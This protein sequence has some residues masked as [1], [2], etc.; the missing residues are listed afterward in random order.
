M[1]GGELGEMNRQLAEAP[2]FP[3]G[4]KDL[5]KMIGKLALMQVREECD[6]A[7][8]AWGKALEKY[9]DE[10]QVSP[11]TRRI[12]DM[13]KKVSGALWLLDYEMSYGYRTVED[14]AN[15]VRKEV[16][17]MQYYSFLRS[18]PLD[19]EKILSVEDGAMFV[20]RFTFMDWLWKQSAEKVA[21]WWK[22]HLKP[23]MEPAQM[24]LIPEKIRTEI[25]MEYLGATEIP[26]LWQ[27]ALCNSVCVMLDLESN[28]VG[29]KA[30]SSN[31]R[32]MTALKDSMSVMI[33]HPVLKQTVEDAYRQYR[34]KQAYQLPPCE[35][36]EVFRKLTE[37]YKGKILLVDFWSISCGPCRAAIENNA[38]LK[39]KWR[40]HKDVQF[41]FITSEGESPEQPYNDYVE[42]HL[43][44]EAVYRIPSSDYQHLRELF[45][46]NG[47][48]RYC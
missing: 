14:T 20:N 46:F 3:L 9:M 47:I 28:D 16:L 23:G 11:E 24:E 35:G 30:D 38:D 5:Q 2:D 33:A 7:V 32:I 8:E 29:A 27:L 25:L 31:V 44:G 19:D 1:Y 6:R 41:I 18:V 12:L 22:A 39:A 43:K 17:P 21:E 45:G 42:K 10:K 36:T 4:Y 48:P 37:P 40:G 15:T 26:F 13:Q 34:E